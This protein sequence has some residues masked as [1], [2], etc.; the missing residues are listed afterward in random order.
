MP[1]PISIRVNILSH[2]IFVTGVIVVSLL[3]LQFYFS[4]QLALSAAEKTFLH[5]SQ[6][7]A[8]HVQLADQKSKDMLYFT[9]LFPPLH[10][11]K[12]K[13]QRDKVY[14]RKR[15]GHHRR[16]Q[17][18]RGDEPRLRPGKGAADPGRHPRIRRNPP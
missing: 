7:I 8:Q 12:T 13:E 9:E 18:A 11:I 14:R 10:H 5:T 4:R 16:G 2:F 15:S 3:L 17:R 6:K 1:R